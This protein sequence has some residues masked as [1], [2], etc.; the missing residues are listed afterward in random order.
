[1]SE[2]IA[3]MKSL[4]IRANYQFIPQKVEYLPDHTPPLLT[5]IPEV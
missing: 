3:E 5:H 1:M 4:I 2:D